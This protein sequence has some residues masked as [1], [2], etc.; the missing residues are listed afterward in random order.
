MTTEFEDEFEDMDPEFEELPFGPATKRESSADIE[1]TPELVKLL[2]QLGRDLEKIEAAC[3][4]TRHSSLIGILEAIAYAARWDMIRIAIDHRVA[5]G[6]TNRT[7][8]DLRAEFVNGAPIWADVFKLHEGDPRRQML[9]NKISGKV[10]KH[11][12]ELAERYLKERLD[13][14]LGRDDARK[15][16]EAWSRF[17]RR[18]TK[19]SKW[20]I[21]KV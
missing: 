20:P 6:D 21:W 8:P 9:I 5:R 7:L 17:D 12:E 13:K 11:S 14:K 4:Q 3:K 10:T 16:V 18:E 15:A 1:L 2:I 19:F